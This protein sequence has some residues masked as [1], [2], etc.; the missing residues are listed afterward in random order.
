M[1]QKTAKRLR[2]ITA[3]KEQNPAK[4]ERNYK[5]AKKNWVNLDISQKTVLNAAITRELSI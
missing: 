2:K 5:A 3:L 4:A 1:N